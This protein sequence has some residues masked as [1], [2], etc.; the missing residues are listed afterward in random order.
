MGIGSVHLA[1]DQV[2]A[3]HSFLQSGFSVVKQIHPE[4]SLEYALASIRLAE[5]HLAVDENSRSRE[6]LNTA[7][8]ALQNIE[9]EESVRQEEVLAML[10][11]TRP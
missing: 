2:D 9:T 6:L 8:E 11:Q 7:L 1:M 3:A 5:Y 10:R 4:Q